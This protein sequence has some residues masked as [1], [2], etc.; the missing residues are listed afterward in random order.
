MA[1]INAVNQGLLVLNVEQ[2]KRAILVCLFADIPLAIWGGV[3]IG[4]SQAVAQVAKQ[5]GWRL[6][7][8]RLSDKEP[9]DLGGIPYPVVT[10]WELGPDGK[11]TGKSSSVA[12]ERCEIDG[13]VE[14]LVSGLLPFGADEM[15]ILLFDEVD[16]TDIGVLNAL[17]QVV[18]DRR[19]N[20]HMLG[21]KVRIVMAGN[22]ETDK[23]TVT[24]TEAARSRSIH[25]YVKFQLETWID[26]ARE[27][28]IPGHLI[29]WAKTNPEDFSGETKE[30]SEIAMF[31]PR[32]AVMAATIYEQAKIMQAEGVFKV[33][34]II[35]ALIQGSI[36]KA[37]ST[38]YLG[39]IQ[40]LW[41]KAPT[42]EEIVA[43]PEGAA[44]PTDPG[45]LFAVAGSLAH[46]AAKDE[47]GK[48]TA[49]IA[50]Y[51]YR[52]GE[53]G[54]NAE[55]RSA[56]FRELL[57]KQPK[58]AL[59]KPYQIWNGTYVKADAATRT[60]ADVVQ[61]ADPAMSYALGKLKDAKLLPDTDLYVNRVQ[62]F[63]S[64]NNRYIISQER[65]TG[66]WLD[67]CRGFLG[68]FRDDPTFE[69]QHIQEFLMGIAE[70]RSSH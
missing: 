35:P 4:K 48:A 64:T 44:I 30:F 20:G 52:W 13:K 43:D 33:D 29:G 16:R 56:F 31:T 47:D 10:F 42:P 5:L 46:I 28:N 12:L 2:L 50:T 37:K 26:W 66:R 22:G 17:L 6:F 54:G 25:V 67:S 58:V 18:L 21:S 40:R 61:T 62:H 41:E 36:T 55:V 65:S 63:G 11:R 9:S 32:T 27:E 34:D 38:L 7:D 70:Y 51:A 1:A 59:T 19:I 68:R 3:G 15:T 69:C 53:E 57:N 23:G 45:T 14:Y 39:Y 49:A 60:H 8:V 24:L